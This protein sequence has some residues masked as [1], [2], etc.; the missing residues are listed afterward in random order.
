MNVTSSQPVSVI[1]NEHRTLPTSLARAPGRSTRQSEK[2]D[3]VYK[4]ICNREEGVVTGPA[5][6]TAT[7]L[8]K[9]LLMRG[10]LNH[11]RTR[12]IRCLVVMRP[13]RCKRAVDSMK[14]SCGDIILLMARTNGVLYNV[15]L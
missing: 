6:A 11:R 5:W 10:L 12:S 7:L 1:R 4:D 14:Y 8:Q 2:P 3:I 15:C 9:R 13:L